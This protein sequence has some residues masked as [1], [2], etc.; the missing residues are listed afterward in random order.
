MRASGSAASITGRLRVGDYFPKGSMQLTR[1]RHYEIE[2]SLS[3]L[4]VAH[5]GESAA[6]LKAFAHEVADFSFTVWPERNRSCRRSGASILEEIAGRDI[7]KIGDLLQTTGADPIRSLAC[8][9]ARRKCDI[10]KPVTRPR[11]EEAGKSVAVVKSGGSLGGGEAGCRRA[12][13]RRVSQS[14]FPPWPAGRPPPRP[15]DGRWPVAPTGSRDRAP[16]AAH[17]RRAGRHSGDSPR[18]PGR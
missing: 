2:D 14:L 1:E 13:R 5:G 16:R 3:Y 8:R 12:S 15:S 6:Q 17:R 9:T 18:S 10:A 11:R 7:E 4:G